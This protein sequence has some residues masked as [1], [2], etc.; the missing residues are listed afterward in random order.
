MRTILHSLAWKEWHEHKWKFVSILAI[1]WTTAALA[2]FYGENDAFAL[3]ACIVAFCIIPLSVFVG[4]GTAASECSRGTLPF[5]QALPA[6]M[7]PIALTNRVGRF[8]T[9][10]VLW[11]GSLVR[12]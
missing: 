2:L 1:L 6:P 5:L 7:W 9:A 11:L 8:D 10:A 12:S 4:L 3:A